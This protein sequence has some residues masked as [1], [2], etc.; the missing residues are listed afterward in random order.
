[1]STE[2]VRIHVERARNR[3]KP[4]SSLDQEQLS[5][6]NQDDFTDFH[7]D[8]DDVGGCVIVQLPMMMSGKSISDGGTL[9][10]PS[11][12]PIKSRSR[13]MS[14]NNIM[15]SDELSVGEL[16]TQT[17]PFSSSRGLS[18]FTKQR[19]PAAIPLSSS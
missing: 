13:K 17:T 11:T 18:R 1:M 2:P 5:T 19:A 7:L 14:L 10:S 8:V 3:E 9:G 12:L 6:P 16:S 15:S 4:Q